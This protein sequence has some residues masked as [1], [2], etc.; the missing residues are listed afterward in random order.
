[1]LLT[2]AIMSAKCLYFAWKIMILYFSFSDY[3]N[4]YMERQGIPYETTWNLWFNEVMLFII[5]V[6]FLAITY[7]QLRRMKKLN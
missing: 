7:I 4:D 6:V 5:A 2:L 3:G 1:M